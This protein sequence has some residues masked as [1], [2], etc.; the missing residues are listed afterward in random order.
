MRHLERL[1]ARAPALRRVG[2]AGP[3]SLLVLLFVATGLR[4]IDF[5]GH[6][7]EAKYQLDPVHEMLVTG[8]SYPPAGPYPA[9]SKWLALLPALPSGAVAALSAGAPGAAR[10]AMASVVEQP[11]YVLVARPWFLAVS[12]LTLVWVWLA[13]RALGR[14][15]WEAF[16]AAAGVGLSWEFAY[17]ARWI[18]TDCLLVEFAALTT[19]LGARFHASGR[20]GWLYASAIAAGFGAGS[21]F[22]G[23]LLL[24]P[25]LVSSIATP[26]SRRLG[27]HVRRGAA[28]IGTAFAAFVVTTPAALL[29]PRSFLS[30]LGSIMEDY[31]AGPHA[32]Y[33]VA[34]ASEHLRLA[35][36]YLALSFFSP[37]LPV[38]LGLA[39]CALLGAVV[40]LRR[41]PRAGVLLLAF[42]LVYLAIFCSLFRV[43]IARNELVVAP[44]MALCAARGV[45]DVAERFGRRWLRLGWGALVVAGFGAGAL[46]LVRAAESIQRPDPKANVR[47]ALSYVSARPDR[48]FRLS[49]RVAGSA[50]QQ[51][52]GIPPN[53]R[54]GAPPEAVVFFARAEGPSARGWITNDPWLTQAIFGPREVNF[55]W[56]A[57]WLGRDRIVVMS[58]EKFAALGD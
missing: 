25:V 52:L 20:S 46:F 8:R 49:P 27:Q 4:G 30:A 11:S 21:K 12:G 7:D 14:A 48:H 44:A 51:G 55:N 10:R 54:G 29:E 50:L 3:L 5:G 57:T 41:D 2:A 56:Y 32:G 16:V 15:R 35:L 53:A 22:Q 31:S 6:W 28:L 43:M 1:F 40:W 23:V 42:P 45:T 19:Y 33:A 34:S 36:T 9:L 17:H 26:P 39:A 24:V 58:V 37:Y 47:E 13:A 18:A 38:S